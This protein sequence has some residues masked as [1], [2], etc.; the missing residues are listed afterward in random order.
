[1]TDER[2]RGGCLT[3]WLVL[4]ILGATFASISN[5]FL[6][7]TLGGL[8]TGYRHGDEWVLIA[9]G[10]L[11]LIQLVAAVALML[12]QKWGFYAV[13]ATAVA[14]L[15]IQI[16]LGFPIYLYIYTFV[17]PL[18]LFLLMK[19][20]WRNFDSTGRSVRYEDEDGSPV[21][22]GEDEGEG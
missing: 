13:V 18:I 12:W 21:H 5:F 15:G 11:A 22:F 19:P 16:Y 7:D 1:M 6:S 14:S 4:M 17:G 8:S 20:M 9:W 3:A 2:N 10:V